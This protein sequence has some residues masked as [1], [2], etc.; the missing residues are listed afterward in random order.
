MKYTLLQM[1][2]EILSSMDSDEV[3]SISDTTEATQVARCIRQAYYDLIE[4]LNPPEHY[5]QFEL[6]ET[7]GASPTMMTVPS[8]INKLISIKYDKIAD[9]ETAMNYQDVKYLPMKTFMDRMYSLNVDETNVGTYDI[10]VSSDTIPILYIDDKAPEYYTTFGEDETVLFDSYDSA[11][12]SYLRKAKTI[13]YGKK[14]I[15]FSLVDGTTPDLDEPYF[16][17][18]LNEAKVLAFAELKSVQHAVADRNARRSRSRTQ[19]DKFRIKRESD[20][21]QLPHFG[22]L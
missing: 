20:F 11:V 14:A 15:A 13:C 7:S 10:T 19:A 21:D 22:R 12:D 1:T 9:G 18:L 6:T 17:R 5:S 3:T 8:D 16:S 2:Q 4:D